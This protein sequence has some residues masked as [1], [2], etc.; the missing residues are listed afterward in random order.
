MSND[1]QSVSA[2]APVHKRIISAKI[3]RLI[4]AA[5]TLCVA[6][7]ASYYGMLLVSTTEITVGPV[8]AEFSL[9]P[10]LHGK[11]VIDL[12]PA[13]TIEAD[14]HSSPAVVN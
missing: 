7:I 8:R 11:T 6:V 1:R 3:T 2:K 9:K 12:P 14:T 13:G 10:A 5:F 4:F